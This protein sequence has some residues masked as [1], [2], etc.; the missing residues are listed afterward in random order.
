MSETDKPEKPK[1]AAV[2]V[3]DIEA[4]IR[5]KILSR[6]PRYGIEAYKYTYEALSYT[7]HMMGRDRRFRLKDRHVTGRELLEGIRRCALEQFGPLAMTVFSSW[8]VRRTED[9]GEIV[10][11]LVENDLLGK[12]ETDA[13]EDFANGF[14]FK[15]AFGGPIRIK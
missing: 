2:C 4:E 8:G 3:R 13:R 11:N 6:D 5:R 10:F 7:Q 12:T 1:E 15:E 9:F 14:D